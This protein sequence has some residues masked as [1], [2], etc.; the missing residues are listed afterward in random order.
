MIPFRFPLVLLPRVLLATKKGR[1]EYLETMI[2][3]F[4]IQVTVIATCNEGWK[5]II[6]NFY[7]SGQAIIAHLSSLSLPP[8]VPGAYQS[9]NFCREA[10]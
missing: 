3:W 6:L 9:V 2:K 10:R 5:L 8:E 1:G 4:R 7:E